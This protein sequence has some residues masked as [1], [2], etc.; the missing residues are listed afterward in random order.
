[1]ENLDSNRQDLIYSS[2]VSF[3]TTALFLV[4]GGYFLLPK[5]FPNAIQSRYKKW[6]TRA[7]EEREQRRHFV[8]SEPTSSGGDDD[9]EKEDDDIVFELTGWQV[10]E[11]LLL[12][13]LILPDHIAKVAAYCRKYGRKETGLNAI[14]EELYDDAYWTAQD[15]Q[16][17]VASN[18]MTTRNAPPLYGIPI[19]V[20]ESCTIKGSYSTAGLACRLAKR[21]PEDCLA[22]Q[23]IRKAG[24]IP[25]CTG[26]V[27]Q[28]MMLP[29]SVNYIW[30]RSRNPWNLSRAVGGSSGGDAALVASR[31]VH[32]AMG[33][34]VA[35][36]CR[37][38]ACFNGIVGFKPSA[39]R[40]SSKGDSIPR[41]NNRVNTAV[42][43]PTVKG[44]LTRCVEDAALFMKAFLVPQLFAGD[45][46]A[47][48]IP[49]D[50][51]AYR[52]K[53]KL[54]IGYFDNDGWFEPCR[55]SKRA[56]G[57]TIVGLKKAGHKCIPFQPPRDG[58]FT[59]GLL[60]A[61]NGAEG[62]MKS[63]HDALEGEKMIDE[64][65]TLIMASSLPDIVRWFFVRYLI[66][67]RRGHLLRQVRRSGLSAR[68]LGELM[69]DLHM[70]RSEWE[71]AFQKNGI[72]AVIF[73]GI[74]IPA[75]LHGTSGKLTSALSYMFLANL[76][77]WPSGVVPVT[78]IRQDEASYYTME[79]LPEN[80]RDYISQLVSKNMKGCAGMPM[81][82]SIMTPLYRDEVC[83]RVMKEVE[84][85]VQFT[86]QPTAFKE[87]KS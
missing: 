38:P 80:Q 15:C 30:G 82:V 76:L 4:A 49:F 69:S 29:E 8:L 16:A 34:D 75:F 79:E 40:S 23:V 81:S 39:G 14:A 43:I 52:S 35:G 25:V 2:L 12:K 26:N 6:I 36:S 60:V 74:P 31:C 70:L 13:E 20:K 21:A 24:A 53:S 54:T 86:E 3:A 73:P 59:Y 71:L 42:A 67:E 63:Y 18:K 66:D 28:I 45:L 41:K 1:M 55:T 72:D 58:W 68:D 83:L 9:D 37:I 7:R 84:T 17:K 65:N 56:I 19:S 85:V 27:P 51:A 78:T 46:N 48:P 61:I 77:R 5:I 10:R 11:A 44:P 47:V 57:E 87:E 64:Y 32:M 33:S 62:S 22:V 50:D